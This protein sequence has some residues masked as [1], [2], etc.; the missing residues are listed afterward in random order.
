M[1]P[2]AKTGSI[3]GVVLI[4]VGIITMVIGAN[5]EEVAEPYQY[6]H[7]VVYEKSGE[8]TTNYNSSFNLEVIVDFYEDCQNI[9]LEIKDSNNVVVY[10]EYMYCSQYGY[11]E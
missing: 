7:L 2:S 4:F 3:V 10:D 5:S 6:Y 11:G 8:F 9:E 1:A